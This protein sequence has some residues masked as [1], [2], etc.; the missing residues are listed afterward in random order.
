[1]YFGSTCYGHE[2]ILKINP[3]FG[4]APTFFLN[5]K[6]GYNAM[7]LK[8]FVKNRPWSTLRFSVQH[9][10]QNSTYYMF[11]GKNVFVDF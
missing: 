3:Y 8:F 10:S 7:F 1:M 2:F 11:Y 6:T 4:Y 5:Y 9:T